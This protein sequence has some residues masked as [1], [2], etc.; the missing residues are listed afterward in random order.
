MQPV[1]EESLDL[2]RLLVIDDD[3]VFRSDLALTLARWG[4]DVREA[5]GGLEGLRLMS[6]W[7]PHLV[8]CDVCM[9]QVAGRQLRQYLN[10]MDAIYSDIIFFFVSSMPA[11]KLAMLSAEGGAD[12]WYTKPI[13]TERLRADIEKHLTTA[14]REKNPDDDASFELSQ[15]AVSAGLIAAVIFAACCNAGYLVM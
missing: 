12:A 7:R 8:L 14:N 11:E 3:L 10:N 4:Y 2:K 5:A 1:V 13:E 6:E 9:P 15:I